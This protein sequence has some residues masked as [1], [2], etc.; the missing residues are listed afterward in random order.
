MPEPLVEEAVGRF[1]KAKK[2]HDPFVRAYERRE[3]S[4]RGVL[5]RGAETADNWKH[6]YHPKYCFNLIET[7]VSSTVEMGLRFTARPA[8]RPNMAL[9]E[10]MHM[11]VQAE[12]VE[13]VLRHEHRID[14][15]DFKQRPLFL[16]GAIGGT[17]VGKEYWNYTEGSVRR[18]G[19]KDVPVHGPDGEVLMHVPTVTEIVETDVLRDHST[20]EVVDPRDFILHESAR[21]LQPWEPGGAQHLFHRCWYSMEQLKGWERAGFI[22]NVDDLVESRDFNDEHEDREKAVFNIN[23]TKDLIEVLEYWKFEDGQVWRALIGQR[24]VVLRALEPSPFWHGGYPFILSSSMPYPFSPR[25]TSD[26]ELIE[27]LQAALWEIQNQTLDNIELINNFITLIRSD[28]KDPDAF[29]AYP[30]AR[31]PVEDITQVS[32]LQ[33]PYQLANVTAERESLIKG[34]LQNVTSASPFASGSDTQTVENKTA[35]GASIVMNAAQQRMI[36]KKYQAQQGLRQEANMRLKNCQQFITDDRL[37]HE[38]GEDGRMTFRDTSPLDIQGEFLF[39]LEPMGESEMRQE[40]RA[41]STQVTQVL[42]QAAPVAAAAGV[43]LNIREV[44]TWMLKKGWRI[45]DA[46]RFFSQIPASTGAAAAP[47]AP[48]GAQAPGTQLVPPGAGPP[49]NPLGNLG[50][51]ADSAVDASSPSARGGMSM[52]PALML[53]RSLAMRGGTKNA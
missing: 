35:T 52:S 26:V 1:E 50:V 13:C 44:L 10:A 31:W 11:L 9:D 42:L 49:Q 4:Y 45:D 18:Q 5:T 39:E 15:M 24:N 40:R 17:G 12:T 53:Q 48:P 38:V 7:V 28:V 47:G 14:E 25:G 37:L 29:E 41:E 6:H 23:R 36:A 27:E 3:R 16:T 46:D 8:P 19:V 22:K 30:G 33:P 51:T 21:N 34:D 2:S 20:F 32:M 43:P